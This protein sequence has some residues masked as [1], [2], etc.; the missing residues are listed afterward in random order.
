[1]AEELGL[2]GEPLGVGG[3]AG[4]S[5]ELEGSLSGSPLNAC[6]SSRL[7]AGLLRRSKGRRDL[8]DNCV[9]PDGYRKLRVSCARGEALYQKRLEPQNTTKVFSSRCRP[10]SE[11]AGAGGG[12]A[13]GKSCRSQKGSDE[14]RLARVLGCVAHLLLSSLEVGEG[15]V[16]ALL[17]V[18]LRQAGLLHDKLNQIGAIRRVEL[19]VGQV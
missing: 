11:A 4:S 2:R 8:L 12:A 15:L 6:C 7:A 9:L 5:I 3:V 18:G 1:M 17:G 13:D 14:R 10:P 16:D 19:R